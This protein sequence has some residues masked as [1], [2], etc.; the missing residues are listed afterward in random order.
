MGLL[1]F[2]DPAR[3]TSRQQALPLPA[4]LHYTKHIATPPHALRAQGTTSKAGDRLRPVS[5]AAT[6]H[7]RLFENFVAVMSR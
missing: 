3:S 5:G 4:P 1:L 2:R 6:A 7:G